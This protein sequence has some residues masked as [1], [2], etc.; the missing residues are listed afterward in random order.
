MAPAEDTQVKELDKRALG[1]AFE[2]ILAT[3][4]PDA[5]VSF[6]ISSQD[7]W[8]LTGENSEEAA[9]ERLDLI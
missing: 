1:Q 3:L 5:K 7:D 2:V 8:R 9:E 4:A 6:P